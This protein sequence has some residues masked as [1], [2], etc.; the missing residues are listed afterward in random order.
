M[1]DGD[2]AQLRFRSPLCGRSSRFEV[3]SDVGVRD[4][5][6][7]AGMFQNKDTLGVI[8]VSTVRKI[9]IHACTAFEWPKCGREHEPKST[10]RENVLRK[11]RKSRL[12]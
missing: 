4:R 2:T 11:G 8:N 12:L 10:A 6:E 5:L 7:L 3:R 9:V 1:F